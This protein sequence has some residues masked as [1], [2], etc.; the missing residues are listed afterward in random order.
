MSRY[1]RLP[2]DKCSGVSLRRSSPTQGEKTMNTAMKTLLKLGSLS[3]ALALML[4]TTLCYGQATYKGPPHNVIYTNGADSNGNDSFPELANTAYTDVIVNFL[5]VDSNC[6]LKDQPSPSQSEMQT[7]HNAGKNVL[8][9]FGNSTSAA[10]QACSNDIGSLAKQIADYVYANGFNGVDIDFEDDSAF[11]NPSDPHYS[12]YDGVYFLTQLTN[13]LWDQLNQ[14]PFL[15]QNIIT[16]APQTNYWLQNYNYPAPPYAEVFSQVGSFIAWFNNQTYNSCLS[17]G[18]PGN[19]GVDCSAND[20]ISN[21]EKIVNSVR[22]LSPIKLVVGVPVSPCGT[23]DNNGNCTGDGYLP[24]GPY[25]DQ[26][27]ND[28]STAIAQ[29]E[30]AYPNQFGGV[31]GWNYLLDLRDD[32]DQWSWS[33]MQA[34]SYNEALPSLVDAQ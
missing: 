6:K 3:L 34:L 26:S 18:G 15:G 28:V 8:I 7:L 4:L 23:T 19:G 17:A 27:G 21:Y 12:G 30:L 2:R 32:S 14:P 22:G 13:D 5:T 33:M 24:A 10:Y 9:A 29:L 16:H 1:R 11:L 20:K 25:Y 31:M